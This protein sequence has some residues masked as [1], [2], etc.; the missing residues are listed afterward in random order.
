MKSVF[1]G[2][3]A[4]HWSSDI[5]QPKDIE[6]GM[7]YERLDPYAPCTYRY[8]IWHSEV[9]KELPMNRHHRFTFVF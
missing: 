6:I 7:T 2:D 3:L 9:A 4:Q 1:A 5:R 8:L